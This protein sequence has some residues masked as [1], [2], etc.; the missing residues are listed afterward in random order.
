[1][2]DGLGPGS[3][4]R[5]PLGFHELLDRSFLAMEFFNQHVLEHESLAARPALRARAEAVSQSLFDLY[6]AIGA[7]ER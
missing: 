1:M 3:D 2:R 4:L 5:D 7:A 6:Q